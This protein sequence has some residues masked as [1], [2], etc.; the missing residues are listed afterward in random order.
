MRVASLLL[1]TM[2]MSGCATVAFK[3]PPLV[4]YTA[5]EQAEAADQ[6]PD[7]IIRRMVADY[8]QLRAECRALR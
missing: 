2:L 5:E 7:G 3:C 1:L 4:E 8:G 6:I